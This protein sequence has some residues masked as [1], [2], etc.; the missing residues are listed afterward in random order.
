MPTVKYTDEQGVM[1]AALVIEG[2]PEKEYEQG[3]IL[4]PPDLSPLG[5]TEEQQKRL[6]NSLVEEGLYMAP[7]LT[8]KRAKLQNILKQI[9]ITVP[10][11]EVISLFQYEYYGD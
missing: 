8:G 6:H 9:G 11:R 3:A 7:L 1:W 5:L 4:G 2:T 10:L